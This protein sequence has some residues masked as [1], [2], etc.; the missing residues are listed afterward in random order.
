MS[1]STYLQGS[2]SATAAATIRF[3]DDPGGSPTTS[4]WVVAAGD[5]WNSA[6]ELVAAWTTQLVADLGAG[7]SV[8][9]TAV[10]ASVHGICTVTTT[11][12]AFDIVWS[13][14]GDGTD[15]RD[16]LGATGDLSN[17][18]SGQTFQSHVPASFC[19]PYGAIRARRQSTTRP[20][21][22]MLR[23]DN[24]TQTQHS[25]SLADVDT[26][27]VDVELVWGASS[28]YTGHE[29]WEAF[30]DAV[31]DEDGGG[32][33]WSLFHG[34]PGSEDQWVCRWTDA[35]VMSH[36]PRPFSQSKQGQL[37]RLA[38]PAEAEVMPW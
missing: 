32:E 9:V 11:G 27:I 30:V 28:G 10:T 6:D 22:R 37:Y 33:P 29:R 24:T 26:A 7:F 20:H 19:P 21:A 36:M 18:P 15:L 2:F 12:S 14:S 13:Q 16:W 31:F 23:L 8:A 34:L 35:P 4:D 3:T 25:T 5:T 17:Q 1:I 38:F